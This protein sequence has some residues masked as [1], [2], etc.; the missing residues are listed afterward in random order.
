M[1]VTKP[2]TYKQQEYGQGQIILFISEFTIF[3]M[4]LCIIAKKPEIIFHV[5]KQHLLLTLTYEFGTFI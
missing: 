2:G 5:Y 4:S 3:R 1:R